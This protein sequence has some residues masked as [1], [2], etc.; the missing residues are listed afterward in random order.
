MPLTCPCHS[1][2]AAGLRRQQAPKGSQSVHTPSAART[3]HARTPTHARAPTI[4]VS[5]YII[6]TDSGWWAGSVP[7]E[8]GALDLALDAVSMQHEGVVQRGMRIQARPADLAALG[9][10]AVDFPGQGDRDEHLA[11]PKPV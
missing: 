5:T 9:Q 1:E 3:R 8:D 11:E 6:S 4:T 2:R 7:A 10:Y